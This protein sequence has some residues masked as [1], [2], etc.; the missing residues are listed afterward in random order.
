VVSKGY[1]QVPKIV[2]L[3]SSNKIPANYRSI[4]SAEYLWEYYHKESSFVDNGESGKYILYRGVRVPFS[5]ADFNALI[6]SNRFTTWDNKEAR[7]DQISW[8]F[9]NDF[10]E[11]D[12]RVQEAYPS[13]LTET[14]LA[15]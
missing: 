13:N 5:L 15:G 14:K 4:W 9:A 7:V 12:Y 2:P 11:V 1:T 3:N 6:Q 8:N 10:A